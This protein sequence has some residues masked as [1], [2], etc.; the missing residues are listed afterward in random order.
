MLAGKATTAKGFRTFHS[1]PER[2]SHNQLSLIG[3]T[4]L[5]VTRS[6]TA[7]VSAPAA[8]RCGNATVRERVNP[9]C[10]SPKMLVSRRGEAKLS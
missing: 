1:T 6:L 7:S 4:Q 8:H 9:N 5:G 2:F 3:L 10:V